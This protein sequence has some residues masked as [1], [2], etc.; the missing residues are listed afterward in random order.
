MTRYYRFK[1]LKEN[2]IVDNRTTACRWIK[3]Y[4]FPRPVHLGPNTA[5]WIVDEVESWLA[6]RA[7][8]R[9]DIDADGNDADGGDDDEDEDAA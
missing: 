3:Q 5:A 6:A 9:V 7:A 1:D 8:E 4:G 2:G